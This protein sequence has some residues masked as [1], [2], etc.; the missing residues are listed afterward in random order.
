VQEIEHVA[1]ALAR[2]A[3]AHPLLFTHAIDLSFLL[4]HK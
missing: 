2:P 3:A 1:V 4:S